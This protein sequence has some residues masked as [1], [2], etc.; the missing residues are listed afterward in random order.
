[1][2]K[3]FYVLAGLAIILLVLYTYMGGFTKPDVTLATSKTI[4]VA[5]Q[6]FEGSVK[7]ET[8]GN[9]FQ[10]A[11]KL[12]E[13][14]ELEGVLGNIYYND[15]DKSGDSLK[16][17]VGVIVPNADVKLPEGYTMRTV[18]GGK[19]VVRAEVN[20]SIMLSPKKLY[21]AVYDYAEEEKLK[22]EDF[23]VEWFPEQDRGIVEI[24]V[25]Q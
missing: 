24:P 25:K 2:R 8:L 3:L 23:Y 5:G 10:R 14:K 18:E 15:P 6:P 21:G 9:A 7:D 20:A 22:L 11:A 13:S 19:K 12:V 1:M 16:A 4:Y 17:F